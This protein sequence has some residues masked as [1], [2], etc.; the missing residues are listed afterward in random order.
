MIGSSV[1][2]SECPVMVTTLSVCGT[3]SLLSHFFPA[4]P[5]E[6]IT[7]FSFSQLPECWNPGMLHQVQLQK[8]NFAMNPLLEGQCDSGHT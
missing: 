7:F 5:I 6:S 1:D 8:P 3:F 4:S 2:L